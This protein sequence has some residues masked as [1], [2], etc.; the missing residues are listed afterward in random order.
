M[1]EAFISLDIPITIGFIPFE[2]NTSTTVIQPSSRANAS[3][4]VPS[5]VHVTRPLETR[6]INPSATEIPDD[7]TVSIRTYAST[8]PPFPDDGLC[9][10]FLNTYFNQI[11]LSND[12]FLNFSNRF[13][14]PKL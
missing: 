2:E 5:V 14:T 4:P 9:S 11:S 13:R 10:F 3:A 1:S 7:D 8:P 6:P 12:S